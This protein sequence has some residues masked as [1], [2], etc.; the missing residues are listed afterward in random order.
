MAQPLN[1]GGNVEDDRDDFDGVEDFSCNG[2]D[3]DYMMITLSATKRYFQARR[4]HNLL[5]GHSMYPGT[6]AGLQRLSFKEHT[7][8]DI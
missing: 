5:L 7:A 4:A 2:G 3:Y 1:I 8:M 6:M